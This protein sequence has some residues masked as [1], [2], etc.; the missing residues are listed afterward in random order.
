MTATLNDQTGRKKRPELSAEAKAAAELVRAAKEQGLSL[1]GPD[2]LLKQLTKTVLETALNEEMTDHLGYEKHEHAGAGSG[3]VRNGSRSKTVLTEASGP[4]QIDVPRDRAGT[5]EPQIVRKRQRRLSGVDEVVLS[6]YAKGL[7]T[8]GISAHFAEIYGASVSKETIS[9]ITDKVI[10]E[11]TD[12]SHRPLDE[13]YAAVF[14]D[15]I[16]VKVRDG[17]VANRPFYAAIGVTLDGEKDVLGLWAGSGGEGAKFWM[18][19][20]TDL[21][22]RGVKDVFF[23]VC[24]GLKGLPEVV[25][26]VWPR[27]VVHTCV[28]HLIRNT[29][30]LTSRK[31][32]DEIK[33]DIK[34]IY[35]AVNAD[36]A[37]AAFDDLADKW[38]GRYPA[39]IRLWDNAWA[40]FIPFLDYDL[41]IR[42][43]ICSTN[44]IESLN[45]RYR[46]A[47]K[48]R[49]HFPDELAALKCLYLVT[50]SLDPTGTGRTRWMMRWKPA[51]NAF[52]ITFSD[53]F[54]AAETY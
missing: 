13:I 23:L 35:T 50:R 54:P 30:R 41:E 28:I 29:F 15:A 19:V 32:W 10:E 8:G 9:R 14:I 52:A 1:T 21:R 42:T 49:G 7:T 36:A 16:V 47:V 2:G 17:Q 48:A 45:A 20:L 37:R 31:Y 24:D 33:R 34:P 12:W 27:T 53:R 39:V 43:V 40:E 5:F 38:G 26:N 18:S 4:V 22:N 44:A 6:L 25:T 46:R 51:L 11:M 3:N